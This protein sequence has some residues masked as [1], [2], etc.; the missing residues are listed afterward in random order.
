[1][2][3]LIKWE[4]TIAGFPLA[5]MESSHALCTLDPPLSPP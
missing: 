5:P 1:M 4:I 2:F 3:L